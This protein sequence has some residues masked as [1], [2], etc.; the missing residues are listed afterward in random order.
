MKLNARN[1]AALTPHFPLQRPPLSQSIPH[2]LSVLSEKRSFCLN[3]VTLS[4][5]TFE[6]QSVT[7]IFYINLLNSLLF[8]CRLHKLFFFPRSMSEGWS[9]VEDAVA[10]LAKGRFV[11]VC[12]DEIREDEGDLVLAAQ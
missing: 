5:H 9:S 6:H 2:L 8:F 11:V 12:D 7:S 10:D 1:V 3:S 4:Q